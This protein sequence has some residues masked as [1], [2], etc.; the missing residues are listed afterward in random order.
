MVEVPESRMEWVGE[1]RQIRKEGKE[2]EAGRMRKQEK[3]RWQKERYIFKKR[4]N[5]YSEG[6]R[7]LFSMSSH[8]RDRGSS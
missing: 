4:N 7:I 6:S 1:E 5:G 8:P 3:G 2:R